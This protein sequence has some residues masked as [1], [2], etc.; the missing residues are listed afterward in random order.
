MIKL[1]LLLPSAMRSTC[2]AIE[3]KSAPGL[4][5]PDSVHHVKLAAPRML[6][7]RR[8]VTS[9]N[10]SGGETSTTPAANSTRACVASARA[11]AGPTVAGAGATIAGARATTAGAAAVAG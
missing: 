6:P 7:L 10:A 9:A 2:G 3:A 11:D 5:V 8:T 1:M 4:A